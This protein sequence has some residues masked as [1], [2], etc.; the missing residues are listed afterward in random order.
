VIANRSIPDAT[1]MPE[2]AYPDVTEAADWLCD[3]FG[4]SVR[5]RIGNHRAQLVYGDGAMI[6]IELGDAAAPRAD[7]LTHAMLVRVEDADLHRSESRGLDRTSRARR[8]VGGC[9]LP[10]PDKRFDR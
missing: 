6:V 1:V 4:F 2:L 8:L 5:L 7:S 9:P 10:T 3:A